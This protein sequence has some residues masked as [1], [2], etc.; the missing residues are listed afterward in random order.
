ML[1]DDKAL[2][3]IRQLVREA[4]QE[5]NAEIL[6]EGLK[7]AE[8]IAESINQKEVLEK[9]ELKEFITRNIVKLI[10]DSGD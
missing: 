2:E 7:T 9:Q 4:K 10:K 1:Q 5:R 6:T 3:L 8:V